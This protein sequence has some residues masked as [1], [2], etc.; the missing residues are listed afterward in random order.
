[1]MFHSRL[2]GTSKTVVVDQLVDLN[3]RL[4]GPPD[5]PR[6]T[7]AEL[8]LGGSDAPRPAAA[9]PDRAVL[10]R[11]CWDGCPAYPYV[12]GHFDAGAPE[13]GSEVVDLHT[14]ALRALSHRLGLRQQWGD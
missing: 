3:R 14:P 8:G 11:L 7:A 13:S 4:A 1:M 5:P 6:I 9:L 10:I 12:H 2:A